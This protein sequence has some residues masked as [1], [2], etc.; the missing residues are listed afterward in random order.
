[1]ERHG[2]ESGGGQKVELFQSSPLDALKKAMHGTE[3]LG[4]ETIESQARV[5]GII[6]QDKLCDQIDE[7]GHAAAG[8]RRARSRR[9]SMA[10]AAAR[11]AIPA[12]WW[13]TVSASKW[14]TR[15]AKGASSCT[16]ATCARACC[17]RGRP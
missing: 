16:S 14:S 17:A 1:M 12:S 2:V 9:R 3:F 13:P 10:K 4:Y 8:R 6:A 7:V 5:V 11:S 15:Y